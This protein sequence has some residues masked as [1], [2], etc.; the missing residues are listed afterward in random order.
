MVKPRGKKPNGP[1]VI[2]VGRYSDGCAYELDPLSRRR[3][4]ESFPQARQVHRVFIGYDK[5]EDFE[6]V[7]GPHWPQVG[8]ILT[9]LRLDQISRLGGLRVYD[10][11]DETVFWEGTPASTRHQ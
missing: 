5:E 7:H 1:L 3:V 4:N 8:A 11:V 10:P 9:G 6:P 2:N